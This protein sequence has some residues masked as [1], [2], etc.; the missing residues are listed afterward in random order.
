MQA[1]CNEYHRCSRCLPLH[2]CSIRLPHNSRFDRYLVRVFALIDLPV[3][4]NV[5]RDGIART[6][7]AVSQRLPRVVSKETY[8]I[9]YVYGVNA[10]CMDKCWSCAAFLSCVTP[11]LMCILGVIVD[12]FT[13]WLTF[14]SRHNADYWPSRI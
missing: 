11:V 14:F 13:A 8:L 5:S 12:L 7:N 10:V 6:R 4:G 2:T 1:R 3:Y 9:A